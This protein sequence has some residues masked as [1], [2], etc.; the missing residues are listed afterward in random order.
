[1]LTNDKVPD[2]HS[3]CIR[4]QEGIVDAAKN[5]LKVIT[6]YKYASVCKLISIAN[7]N[8]LFDFFDKKSQIQSTD[9]VP[10][11]TTGYSFQYP[12]SNIWSFL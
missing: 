9:H 7:W 1:M 10:K 8:L 3:D 6:I 2:E 12:L 4:K 5:S 11:T